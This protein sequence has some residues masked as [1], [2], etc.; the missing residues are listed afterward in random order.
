[1]SPADP[2]EME[3]NLFIVLRMADEM[4]EL[5]MALRDRAKIMLGPDKPPPEPDDDPR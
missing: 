2:V 4:E 3:R 1:M 5:A